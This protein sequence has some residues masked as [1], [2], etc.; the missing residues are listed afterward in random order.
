M[1][2]PN[3]K[4]I[5]AFS[6]LRF[7]IVLLIVG[8]LLI[9]GGYYQI[10]NTNI[11]PSEKPN[12]VFIAIGVFAIVSAVFVH[13]TLERLQLES[14]STIT[15]K[16]EEL[17]GRR[18]A[19]LIY[20]YARN[21]K[22]IAM[23]YHH[24][25]KKHLPPGRRLETHEFPHESLIG[26]VRDQIGLEIKPENFV[27]PLRKVDSIAAT[28]KKGQT[29][30]ETKICLSPIWIQLEKHEQRPDKKNSAEKITEHYDFIYLC[31]LEKAIRPL[32]PGTR[33][34]LDWFSDADL[35][36]MITPEGKRHTFPDVYHGFE[37]IKKFLQH[38]DLA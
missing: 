36:Q 20:I 19:N 28:D 3:H 16:I 10:Q 12:F 13:F 33:T 26:I 38:K 22:S 25:H 27:N 6:K 31:V 21:E 11:N 4:L 29:I 35:R 17:T 2:L 8:F 7:S 32:G 23:G 15:N 1:N 30:G 37:I 9:L 14:R 34:D 18:F 24:G 5:D